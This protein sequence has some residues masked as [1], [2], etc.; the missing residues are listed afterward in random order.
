M[1][2]PI[3]V[4]K[5]VGARIAANTIESGLIS[6]SASFN[7]LAS[8]LSPRQQ[9]EVTQTVLKSGV[10]VLVLY[11]CALIVPLME[12]LTSETRWFIRYLSLCSSCLLLY[13]WHGES[14]LLSDGASAVDIRT[15]VVYKES[16]TDLQFVCQQQILSCSTSV[17][18]W[19]SPGFFRSVTFPL[20]ISC[21][22]K[23]YLAVVHL[24]SFSIYALAVFFFYWII[25]SCHI[26]AAGSYDF[27][28]GV[29]GWPN[30]F[31]QTF[32]LVRSEND[33]AQGRMLRK[34]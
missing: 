16:T 19:S 20:T 2:S 24:I 13:A 27:F 5:R 17:F 12:H 25:A 28:F 8:P 6:I 9:C 11:D 34:L 3:Q 33:E 18:S 15:L 23:G 7:S 32:G 21:P 26:F 14:F 29:C 1:L 30:Y 4:R 31:V 22:V 10:E